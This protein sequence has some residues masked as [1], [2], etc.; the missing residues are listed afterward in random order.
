MNRF[1][2]L[3]LMVAWI[4]SLVGVALWAQGNPQSPPPA[5]PVQ[6]GQAAPAQVVGPGMPYGP[7]I[8]GADIGFQ[9]V[10]TGGPI[11]TGTIVG[12]LMVRVNGEWMEAQSGMSV[13]R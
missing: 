10:G 12:K 6:R 3:A 4:V 5:A 9:R 1:R 13:V 11:P 7:I 8:S 2:T